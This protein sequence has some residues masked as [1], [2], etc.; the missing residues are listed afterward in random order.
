MLNSLLKPSIERAPFDFSD[1]STTLKIKQDALELLVLEGGLTDIGKV[2][3]GKEAIQYLDGKVK[4]EVTE[5]LKH[6]DHAYM[7]FSREDVT[8]NDKVMM[9]KAFAYQI[10]ERG[11][12]QLNEV[13]IF[14]YEPQNYISWNNENGHYNLDKF[15]DKLAGED[16]WLIKKLI[17]Q[18][19]LFAR[20]HPRHKKQIIP[21][22][23]KKKVFE[24]YKQG[25]SAEELFVGELEP[26]E[27]VFSEYH[28]AALHSKQ[29]K[30]FKKLFG[31]KVQKGP[32]E[33]LTFSSENYYKLDSAGKEL[34]NGILLQNLADFQ[35]ISRGQ[36]EGLEI[37]DIRFDYLLNNAKYLISKA[38][39]KSQNM[40]RMDTTS[41]LLPLLKHYNR[42][43][44]TLRY[45]IEEDLRKLETIP[46]SSYFE[47]PY[48]K[49]HDPESLV[50]AFKARYLT[51]KDSYSK[52]FLFGTAP[53]SDNDD[54]W[55]Y[56][57]GIMED[58]TER[59]ERRLFL[60][61]DGSIRVHI[62]H[63]NFDTYFDDS[64]NEKNE[65]DLDPHNW[66]MEAF[67]H[68]K[69]GLKNTG[70]HEVF[71][72]ALP[73]RTKDGETKIREK[74]IIYALAQVSST[75]VGDINST[76][77]FNSILKQAIGDN[78]TVYL[79]KDCLKEHAFGGLM[80][81]GNY[82]EN[83]LLIENLLRLELKEG[84]DYM[85]VLGAVPGDGPKEIKNKY[86]ALSWKY[87]PSSNKP[88]EMNPEDRTR[89]WR[90]VKEAYD[91]LKKTNN[92]K[93][94]NPYLGRVASAMQEFQATM[95][96]GL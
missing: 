7:D 13:E 58:G 62:E 86:Y 47:M 65:P 29:L 11:I 87:H 88:V 44:D 92:E 90:Q 33:T 75:I 12:S 60:M 46:E 82:T 94:T 20:A 27:N 50:K 52:G 45:T 41:A 37:K 6:Q 15:L 36:V 95:N 39:E 48:V 4:D 85:K 17:D 1:P 67:P 78:T 68:L 49:G 8:L 25:L 32:H 66:V 56:M 35:V 76:N 55:G 21:N 43:V 18:I 74:D 24:G 77:A 30:Q 81:P 16:D 22:E 34:V 10:I 3:L 73:T 28:F 54:S 91:A 40:V 71:E 38:D 14:I 5:I 96:Q 26:F 70:R 61:N 63:T 64:G 72:N 19:D 59:V 9:S 89:I 69:Q 2:K 31:N 83:R 84:S 80:L 93:I 23:V 53:W 57:S 42:M 79:E 51:M